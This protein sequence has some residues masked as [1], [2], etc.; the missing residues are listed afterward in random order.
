VKLATVK[1]G[2]TLTIAVDMEQDAF[3]SP[4]LK[5][6]FDHIVFGSLGSAG[7][8]GVDLAAS[9]RSQAA[10]PADL[11]E[12]RV[13]PAPGADGRTVAEV[14]AQRAAL[15]GKGVA[16]RGKV[17]KFLPGIMG[18]NWI[19]LRDGSGSADGKDND[20][21]VTT[22]AEAA[23]GD[24]VLVR[25]TVAKDKDFGAGYAYTVIVEGATVVK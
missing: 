7:T 17:V 11:G 5:R 8:A 3:E 21:T 13:A 20:L 4:T 19:H 1:K 15:A 23:V 22:A 6:T 16:V 18:K 12:I 14:H 9:H 24:E 25:G 10:P 2:Q